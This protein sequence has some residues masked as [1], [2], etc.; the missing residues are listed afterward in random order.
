MFLNLLLMFRIILQILAGIR[1]FKD[2]NKQYLI[3]DDSTLDNLTLAM[4][5]TETIDFLDDISSQL[6]G[7]VASSEEIIESRNKMVDLFDTSL[8]SKKI[9]RTDKKVPISKISVL[10][11]ILNA[12]KTNRY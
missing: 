1:S 8:N 3:K 4:R 5:E 7:D 10:G 6:D 9:F 12:R 2:Y 11:L